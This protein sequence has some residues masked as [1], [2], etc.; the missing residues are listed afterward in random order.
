MQKR[1]LG[2][3]GPSVSV[4]GVGAMSFAG[5]YGDATVEESH[6]V[7]AAALDLGI[8]HIDTANVY[9]MGRSEEIIGSFLAKQGSRKNDMFTIATKCAISRDADGNRMIRNDRDHMVAEIDGSLK[10]LGVDSVELLY[11]HRRDPKVPIE[12]VTESLASIV[13]SGKVRRIG[14]SEIAPSSLRRAAAVHPIAAVQSEYSLGVRSPELGLVQNC[15]ELGAALV[16]FS[17]VGR[18]ILTDAPRTPEEIEQLQF[19]RDNPRFQAPN[20]AANLAATDR[21][22]DLARDMGTTAASLAIA[23]V[24]HQDPNSI[25][26]PGTRSVD[27]LRELAAGGELT[28]SQEDMDRIE[29]VLPVGWAHGDRYSATQWIGPERYC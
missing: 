17:P 14:F 8:D 16:A 25:T 24:L 28:L 15:A 27:H 29:T 22:R 20:L 10:R 23:W 5:V 21:F 6:A 11:I 7:L 9:G 1:P 12:E 13:K 19:M 18:G 4:V 26:I 2:A 3:N